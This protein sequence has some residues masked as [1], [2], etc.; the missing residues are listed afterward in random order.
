MNKTAGKSRFILPGILVVLFVVII[1]ASFHYYWY[2]FK[3]NIRLSDNKAGTLI[4]IPT[5]SA[6]EVVK[7]SLLKKNCLINEKSFEWLA[8]KKDY[9]SKIK[10]GCYRIKDKMSNNSLINLL[11]SGKQEPVM[12]IFNNIRTRQDLAGRVGKQIEADSVELLRLLNDNQY[13][14]EFGVTPVTAFILF[15]PNSYEFYWNTSAD[16]FIRRM[17]REQ[18]KFW[19][20][21]RIGKARLTG[22]T[23]PEIVTLASIVEKETN[24]NSE[25][26]VIAGVYMNRLEKGWLL[27][28][29]PTLIYAL[30]DYNIHRI[31]NVHKSVVSPFNTYIHPGLPPGPICLPSIASVDAV[32]DYRKHNFMY[33][34]AKEDL[35]GYHNFALTF[36]QHM[37]N[38]AKYQRALNKLNIR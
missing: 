19:N 33:F 3:P 18:K 23:I 29:D 20:E 4:H 9:P 1:T 35:S 38:A 14:Q 22:L 5:G 27:Q 10:P 28:A 32:L 37:R 34:C 25:K 17:Y 26:P 2:I 11:I 24:Q 36:D 12:V 7:D 15:I 30:N 16:Q 6:F 21:A 31:T 8:R 13:L